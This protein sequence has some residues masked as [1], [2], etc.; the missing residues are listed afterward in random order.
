[1]QPTIRDVI[2]RRM[3]WLT[4]VAIAG[5]LLVGLSIQFPRNGQPPPP[6]VI[7][8]FL[9]FAG[10]LLAMQRAVRCL[11]CS[12]PLG[13]IAATIAFGLWGR[14]VNFCPYCGVSLDEPVPHKVIE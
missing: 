6:L 12:T 14:R 9:V 1:M 5:W 10:A 3:R 11:K 8:G 13:K 2:K 7:V 4:L